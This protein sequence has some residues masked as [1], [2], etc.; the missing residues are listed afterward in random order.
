MYIW[1]LFQNISLASLTLTNNELVSI[2]DGAFRGSEGSITQLYLENNRLTDVPREIGKLTGL[3]SLYIAGNPISTFDEEVLSNVSTH[4]ST[5]SFGSKELE[6][7]PKG[8]G[9]LHKTFEMTLQDSAFEV[10]PDDAFEN[11]T[12]LYYF[13]LISTNLRS[14]PVSMQKTN[15]FK[16]QMDNNQNLKADGFKPE[17]FRHLSELRQFYIN[18][19]SLETLPPIFKDLSVL[20]VFDIT[21]T[22]LKSIDDKVFPKN[23]S[24]IFFEFQS[25]NSLFESVPPIL[26]KT[27]S[28]SNVFLQNNKITYINET[29]FAGLNQLFYLRLSGNPIK[30]ISDSAFKHNQK[31]YQVLLDNTELTTIPKALQNAHSLRSVDLTGTRVIC[32]CENLGWIKYWDRK[33]K[34]LSFGGPCANLHMTIDDFVKIDIPNC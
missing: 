9:L 6:E 28:L 24:N 31:L 30:G 20:A 25:I 5:I 27:K 3:Y 32:S 33:Q 4:L 16:L 2:D 34:S 18:N 14:L 29:D 15:L 19:G 11:F 21:N 12:S 26:S 13:T 1:T 22:P 23:F 17:A 8:I 7:W 10:I